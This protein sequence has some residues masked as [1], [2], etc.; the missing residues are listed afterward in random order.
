MI[1]IQVKCLKKTF[2][3]GNYWIVVLLLFGAPVQAQKKN[4]KQE[5]IIEKAVKEIKDFEANEKKQDSIAGHPL[6]SYK[7]EDFLRRYTFY[8]SVEA[9]LKGIDK[10]KL[11]FDEEINYELL[12][13]DIEDDIAAYTFKSYL[14]PILSDEG[15]HT[16]LPIMA[17]GIL[18]TKKEYE[19]YINWMKDIARYVQENLTLMRKGLQL[20]I[21]QPRA[22]L[23]G[24]ENTY[25]QHIVDS[26]EK[27][28]FWK[29]FLQRPF[30]IT[31]DDWEKMKVEGMK[32]VK[33]DVIES[34]RQIKIFFDNE[35]LPKTRT[36][37]G[38]SNFPNGL[39]FYQERVQHYTTTD[40]SYE[41]VYQLGLKEVDRIKR[42][43]QDVLKEA[44]FNGTLQEFISYLRTEPKF[45]A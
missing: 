44:N 8:H 33:E 1:R 3:K 35:Y 19:N 31:E 14:N 32:V 28:V 34:Y 9:K 26:V 5:T 24:Y 38:V 15:F 18:T 2:M 23:N 20:G 12:E 27:S 21:S 16:D 37:I 13:Y 7:E 41:D 22:I 43:M 10:S 36:T 39:A 25:E 11:S 30:A 17:S 40:L 6:G 45:Y 4:A 42:L 29:P